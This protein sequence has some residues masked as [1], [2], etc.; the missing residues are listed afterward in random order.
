MGFV[1]RQHAAESGDAVGAHMSGHAPEHTDTL[2][3][4]CGITIDTGDTGNIGP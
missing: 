4:K 2:G 3:N 1:G